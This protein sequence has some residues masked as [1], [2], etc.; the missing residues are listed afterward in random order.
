MPLFGLATHRAS[1][2]LS[3]CYVTVQANRDNEL[4]TSGYLVQLLSLDVI[5]VESPV[6][7][8][9]VPK[10]DHDM[11]SVAFVQRLEGINYIRLSC[12]PWILAVKPKIKSELFR[13][14]ALNRGGTPPRGGGP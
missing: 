11:T 7:A 4:T 8:L 10:Q 1:F 14:V 6:L 9:V 3:R 13:S 5:A 12:Q 2:C